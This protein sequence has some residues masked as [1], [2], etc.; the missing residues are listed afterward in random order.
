MFEHVLKVAFEA[1]KAKLRE[2][3]SKAVIDRLTAA[4]SHEGGEPV[5][6]APT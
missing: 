5:I 6:T 3:Y 1:V 4:E 2:S